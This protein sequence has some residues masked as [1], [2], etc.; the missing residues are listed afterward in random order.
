MVRKQGRE[1]SLATNNKIRGGEIRY[2]EVRESKLQ[3]GAVHGQTISVWIRL[4]R[5]TGKRMFDMYVL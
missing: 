3:Y 2:G 4:G 1:S 5:K